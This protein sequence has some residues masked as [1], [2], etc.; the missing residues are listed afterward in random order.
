MRRVIK[1][2]L[3]IFSASL[4]CIGF[5]SADSS[6]AIGDEVQL[7]VTTTNM[8]TVDVV[9]STGTITI[10]SP[11]GVLYDAGEFET[12]QV[13]APGESVKVPVNWVSTGATPGM[14]SIILDGELVYATGEGETTHSEISEAFQLYEPVTGLT[15]VPSYYAEGQVTGITQISDTYYVDSP[16]MIVVWINNTGTTQRIPE[17]YTTFSGNGV[18]YGPYIDF[19]LDTPSSPGLTPYLYTCPLP[20]GLGPGSYTYNTKVNLH[21]ISLD[22]SDETYPE[23]LEGFWKDTYQ[24]PDVDDLDEDI[25]DEGPEDLDDDEGG[26]DDGSNYTDDTWDTGDTGEGGGDA[27]LTEEELKGHYDGPLLFCKG[28]KLLEPWL[29]GPFTAPSHLV[30]SEG[31][32]FDPEQV[33]EIIERTMGT[34]SEEQKQEL[35]D[36]TAQKAWNGEPLEEF[37]FYFVTSSPRGESKLDWHLAYYSADQDQ[38]LQDV[39]FEVELPIL[40]FNVWSWIDGTSVINGNTFIINIELENNCGYGIKAKYDIGI[41]GDSDAS[42]E[43]K[44]ECTGNTASSYTRI[45]ESFSVQLRD[46]TPTEEGVQI[47]VTTTPDEVYKQ[48]PAGLPD[49]LD[50]KYLL[51]SLGVEDGETGSAGQED[52]SELWKSTKVEDID[53]SQYRHEGLVHLG[54]VEKGG[55]FIVVTEEPESTDGGSETDTATEDNTDDNEEQPLEE[56]TGEEKKSPG[57]I[58]SIIQ[59]VVD[60]FKGLFG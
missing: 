50:T 60:F 49:M 44:E 18:Q 8:G 6:W 31:V 40:D 24:V 28:A 23:G 16:F 3:L 59:K 2:V 33:S 22:I 38:N 14:Y 13:V 52:F 26:G 34:Y 48:E 12:D 1:L 17:I 30:N 11:G 41:E 21:Y 51:E 25:G 54:G 27:G 55:T 29:S 15:S 35:L 36:V 56:P 42:I 53:F 10:S 43:I 9:Q 5:V 45:R 37:P 46:P 32:V 19:Y 47:K 20:E 57:F 4:F 39:P 7:I 58:Q